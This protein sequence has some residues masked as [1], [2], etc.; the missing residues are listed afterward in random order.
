MNNIPAP[1]KMPTL[2]PVEIVTVTDDD[3]N[4]TIAAIMLGFIGL[5]ACAIAFI[6]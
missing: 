1:P 3:S 2:K 6:V 5:V 4:T